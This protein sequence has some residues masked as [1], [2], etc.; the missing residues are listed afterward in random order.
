MIGGDKNGELV[1][2][3]A[4]KANYIDPNLGLIWNQVLFLSVAITNAV[5]LFIY[6]VP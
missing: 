4:I 1:K 6:F 2:E 3:A 5:L